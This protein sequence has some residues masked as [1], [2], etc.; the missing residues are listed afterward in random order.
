MPRNGDA[1]SAAVG[2]L[3][4]DRITSRGVSQETVANAGGMSQPT[5]SRCLSGLRSWDLGQLHA[6]CRF[7][8]CV[9]SDL[10]AVAEDTVGDS[11]GDN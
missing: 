4:R 5:L 8:G 9:T 3:L 1:L 6:V 7:L 10:I 2:E 11:K